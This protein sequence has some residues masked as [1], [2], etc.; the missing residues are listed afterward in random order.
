MAVTETQGGAAVTSAARRAPKGALAA[1]A[2]AAGLAGGLVLGARAPRHGKLKLRR[3][4]VLGMPIGR[5]STAVTLA[6]RVV[7]ATG[8]A[9]RTADDMHAIREQLEQANRR[10]PVE[11]LLDGLTHRRGAHKLES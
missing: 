4:R 5:R 6:K 9:S 11:V 3:R 2:A 1:G 10:S 7:K 8:K